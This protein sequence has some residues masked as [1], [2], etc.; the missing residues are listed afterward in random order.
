MFEYG[1]LN[2]F[3]LITLAPN[4]PRIVHQVFVFFVKNTT[5]CISI[6]RLMSRM[7]QFQTSA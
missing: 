2:S 4:F 5:L 3:R 6:V 7:L 1:V